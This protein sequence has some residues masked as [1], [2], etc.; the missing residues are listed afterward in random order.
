MVLRPN[1]ASTTFNMSTPLNL[2]VKA[3]ADLDQPDE[4]GIKFDKW[5]VIAIVSV[6]LVLIMLAIIL[7]PR[8]RGSF[9]TGAKRIFRRNKSKQPI[10]PTTNTPEQPQPSLKKWQKPTI[11][12]PSPRP[13]RLQ[14]LSKAGPSRPFASPSQFPTTMPTRKPVLPPRPVV[15][16]PRP[17]NSFVSAS[18]IEMQPLP[19]PAQPNPTHPPR[20]SAHQNWLDR[21]RNI[22][23]GADERHRRAREL[24]VYLDP[25]KLAYWKQV[26]AEQ[27]ARRRW[28]D[29]LKIRFGYY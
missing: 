18:N 11:L 6:V 2:T 23:P 10:L 16:H 22:S 28:W 29:K 5:M 14:Q 20:R 12:P 9:L 27:E 4:S 3:A 7:V 1:Q 17:V 26:A 13:G 8:T 15:P 19:S 25:V 21:A 24:P